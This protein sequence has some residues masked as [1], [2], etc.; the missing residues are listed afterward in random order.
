META[1]VKEAEP[2]TFCG[3]AKKMYYQDVRKLT[4]LTGKEEIRLAKLIEAGEKAKNK[5][6]KGTS[7]TI[8]LKRL[9]CQISEGKKAFDKMV[10]G[11]VRLVITIARRYLGMGLEDQDLIQEGNVGLIDAVKRFDHR[12]G[13]K[14]STYATWRI[15]QKIRVA[16]DSSRIVRLPAYKSQEALSFRKAKRDLLNKKG[17]EPTIWEIAEFMKIDQEKV[18]EIFENSSQIVSL[19]SPAGENELDELGNFIPDNKLPSHH[20]LLEERVLKKSIID[21]LK[22]LKPKEVR[23]VLLRFGFMDGEPFTLQEIGNF[24]GNTREA[25][26]QTEAKAL[27]KLKENSK[28]LA[29]FRC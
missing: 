7:C 8:E 3:D 21:L 16:V 10:E 12:K 18:M 29:D 1:N 14:F 20:H 19:Q 27:T 4:L 23:T 17:Q 15:R 25:V 2:Q 22:S 28:I 6:K 5:L 13:Y 11:N 9:E 24:F 26:R